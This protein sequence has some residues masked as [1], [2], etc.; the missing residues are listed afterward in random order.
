M[1]RYYLQLRDRTAELL[2]PDGIEC[3]DLDAL[4][5]AVLYNARD[6]IAGDAKRGVVDLRF[7]IDAEAE[8]GA[9][10]HSLPFAEAV[11]V[12]APD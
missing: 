5:S 4:R 7:R 10:A 11:N 9:L 12:I 3:C 8:S 2:D 1:T 6:V